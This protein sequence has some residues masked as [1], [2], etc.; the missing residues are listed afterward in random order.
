MLIKQISIFIENHP[1]PLAEVCDILHQNDIDIV[2][3]SL[4]DASD[5]GILRLIVDKPDLAQS[6]LRDRGFITKSADVLAVSM[7]D[8]PGGLSSILKTLTKESISVEYMYA[9]VGKQDGTAV[10]VLSVN[11]LDK[12][13][14]ILKEDKQTIINSRDIYRL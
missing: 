14:S 2:A 12:T 9:F 6:T 8:T 5:F 10:V 7:S 3:L 4:A 13:L 1:G 11:E